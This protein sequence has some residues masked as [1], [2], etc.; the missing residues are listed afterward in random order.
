MHSLISNRGKF[1]QKYEKTSIELFENFM[2]NFNWKFYPTSVVATSWITVDKRLQRRRGSCHQCEML[3][4]AAAAAAAEDDDEGDGRM[5]G[6]LVND[7][8][9]QVWRRSEETVP[10]WRPQRLEHT[11]DECSALLHHETTS[12]YVITNIHLKF[13]HSTHTCFYC[14]VKHNDR[15]FGHPTYLHACGLRATYSAAVSSLYFVQP[16]PIKSDLWPMILIIERDRNNVKLNYYA[17]YLG[18]L[19]KKLLSAH[20]HTRHIFDLDHY[21]GQ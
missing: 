4:A 2:K 18:H 5:L 21:S 19:V 11:A 15:W 7:Q 17:Q 20:I 6:C 10:C 3:L 13:K 14:Y 9:R 16:Q 1:Q 8:Y 12:R